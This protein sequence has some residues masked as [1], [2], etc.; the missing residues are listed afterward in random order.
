MD[1]TQF[2]LGPEDSAVIF[3][4]DGTMEMRVP[5]QNDADQVLPSSMAA[6]RCSVLMANEDLCDIVDARIDA[7][8]ARAK[9][10]AH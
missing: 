1:D 3:R 9:G 5:K 2:T 10:R 8:S 4:S 7:Q 6:F